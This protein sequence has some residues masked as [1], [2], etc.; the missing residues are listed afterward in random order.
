VMAAFDWMS[1]GNESRRE[2]WRIVER[3]EFESTATSAT[4]RKP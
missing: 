3:G 1:N 2:A 4:A